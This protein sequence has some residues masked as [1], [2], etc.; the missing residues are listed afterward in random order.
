MIPNLS[1]LPDSTGTFKELYLGSLGIRKGRIKYVDER[2]GPLTETEWVK[3][4]TERVE[5]DKSLEFLISGPGFGNTKWDVK[6][7]LDVL[8]EIYKKGQPVDHGQIQGALDALRH[9]CSEGFNQNLEAI[10]F[11]AREKFFPMMMR[12]AFQQP[13][14]DAWRPVQEAVLELVWQIL[15]N[16]MTKFDSKHAKLQ[17]ALWFQLSD[18]FQQE[19][20]NMLGI[21]ETILTHAGVPYGVSYVRMKR[22]ANKIAEWRKGTWYRYRPFQVAF[23]KAMADRYGLRNQ[24]RNKWLLDER[25]EIKSGSTVAALMA[26]MLKDTKG[27][28]GIFF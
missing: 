1:Q 10:S 11:L 5:T 26:K 14:N 12:H 13:D 3:A 25:L 28:Y 16:G 23:M 22:L 27:S 15:R 8:A 2:F 9:M 17:D 24:A 20:P 4:S 18:E 21:V 6:R 7:Q 19:H